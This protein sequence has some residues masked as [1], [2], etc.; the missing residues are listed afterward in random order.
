MDIGKVRSF[1]D[2]HKAGGLSQ[3]DVKD[4]VKLVDGATPKQLERVAAELAPVFTRSG[5]EAFEKATGAKVPKAP[6]PPP[7]TSVDDIRAARTGGRVSV[8][9]AWHEVSARSVQSAMKKLVDDGESLTLRLKGGRD[10]SVDADAQIADFVKKGYLTLY[11]NEKDNS[12]VDDDGHKIWYSAH[13]LVPTPKFK[14]LEDQMAAFAK[15]ADGIGKTITDELEKLDTVMHASRV[16]GLSP[17]D[18]DKIKA[19]VKAEIPKAKAAILKYEEDAKQYAYD[20]QRLDYPDSEVFLMDWALRALHSLGPKVD[21]ISLRDLNFTKDLI[22]ANEMLMTRPEVESVDPGEG[23]RIC[24]NTDTLVKNGKNAADFKAEVTKQLHD[25]LIT[26]G[27]QFDKNNNND[28][29]LKDAQELLQKAV[30]KENVRDGYQIGDKDFADHVRG[31]EVVLY[32]KKEKLTEARTHIGA[33]EQLFA[34][35]GFDMKHFTVKV[36]EDT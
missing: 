15:R 23:I 25:A 4:L 35:H 28:K 31:T 33:L 20:T 12:D 22:R 2:K 26:D 32:V 30:G 7:S 13:Y 34:P 18:L 3:L 6:P 1:V 29:V 14:V 8:P 24:F 11:K 27:L 9:K 10:I 5:K 21:Q 36:E 16:N 17:F 19:E